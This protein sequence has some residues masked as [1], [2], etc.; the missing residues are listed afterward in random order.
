MKKIALISTAL[1]MLCACSNKKAA[2]N[3]AEEET[4]GI[5]LD[6]I[7]LQGDWRL[8]EYRVDCASTEFPGDAK[9]K[10][11]FDEPDNTFSLSTDCN[12]I[13]GEFGVENDTI[14]FKNML[15]TEMACDN[16]SVEQDMLRLLNDTSTYATYTTDTLRLEAP[17]IGSAI[18]IRPAKVS[19]K[20]DFI[21][22]YTDSNDGSTL[23]IGKSTNSGASVKISL[24]R[25][26]DIDD[27][28]GTITDHTMTF[29][30]TDAAGNPIQGK[31]TLTGD[32]AT[33]VFT[34]STWD[35]LPNGSTFYF[36]KD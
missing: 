14:C 26:T 12:T 6:A 18:F 7:G 9:Y 23:Q 22:D 30:A 21:G 36:K 15:V 35:N 27:G 19:D 5:Q 24:F 33:L 13:N 11:S 34:E 17:Q 3:A 31:I 20:I 8:A 4:A 28:I 16:M 1:L 25:L 32:T 29:K 2:D 10:L